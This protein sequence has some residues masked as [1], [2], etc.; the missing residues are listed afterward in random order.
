M[1]P[2]G[3]I[4]PTIL[5]KVN[6]CY[7]KNIKWLVT[8]SKLIQGFPMKRKLIW[9]CIGLAKFL[10]VYNEMGRANFPPPPLTD[11]VCN[12]GSLA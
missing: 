8:I 10:T 2:G 3:H 1:Q 9:F 7:K 12:S 5:K 4:Y 6:F 11:P